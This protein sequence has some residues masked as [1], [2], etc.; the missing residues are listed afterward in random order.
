M[1]FESKTTEISPL[2][3]FPIL[4]LTCQHRV[5]QIPRIFIPR[6][7]LPRTYRQLCLSTSNKHPPPFLLHCLYT[8]CLRQE[9][10][11]SLRHC[12]PQFSGTSKQRNLSQGLW[13]KGEKCHYGGTAFPPFSCYP[14]SRS[15]A[16]M[17]GPQSLIVDFL[18]LSTACG[19]SQARDQIC[20]TAVTMLN[21]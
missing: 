6:G 16:Q 11:S 4:T 5:P 19:S 7:Q 20:T 3:R 12:R 13:E 18:A 2:I 9:L 10:L 15:R 21:P 1:E 17:G 8:C 14:L